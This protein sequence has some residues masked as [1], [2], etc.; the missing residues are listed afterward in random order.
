VLTGAKGLNLWS[1]FR[2]PP[3]QRRSRLYRA[4]VEKGL[5]SSVSGALLPTEQPFL[6]TVSATATEG[7]ALA[8]VEAALLEALDVVAREGITGE[9]LAKARAQLKAR[10][11]FDDDS[12]TNIAHQLGYFETIAGVDVIMAAPARIRAVTTDEVAQAAAAVLKPSNR[13]I[14]W[15]DPVRLL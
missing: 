9:E 10:L 13:T 1:S 5:A 2:V 3:P 6:Y 8:A 12:V 7:V 11:V 4:L 15:F 14:G